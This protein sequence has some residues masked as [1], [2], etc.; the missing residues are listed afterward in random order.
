MIAC[1]RLIA[2]NAHRLN[3]SIPAPLYVRIGKQGK[4][5]YVY[6]GQELVQMEGKGLQDVSPAEVTKRHSGLVT[7]SVCEYEG[8]AFSSSPDWWKDT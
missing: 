8:S 6:T 3:L 2:A 7:V 1:F 5:C 4:G